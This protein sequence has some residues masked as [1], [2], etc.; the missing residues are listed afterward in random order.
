MKEVKTKIK[1]TS[2]YM[3]QR[4]SFITFG[5]FNMNQT[6]D[7]IVNNGHEGLEVW[8][9][10]RHQPYEISKVLSRHHITFLEQQLNKPQK[11]NNHNNHNND[12]A[13]Y[14]PHDLDSN[15]W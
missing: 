3:A 4:L 12:K 15:Q 8:T 2:R 9:Y 11:T 13:I 14:H 1:I 6:I 5:R 10:V 7:V